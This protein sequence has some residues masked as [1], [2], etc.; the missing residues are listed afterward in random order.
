MFLELIFVFSLCLCITIVSCTCLS[1]CHEEA[2]FF[3]ALALYFFSGLRKPFEDYILPSYKKV[4]E[5]ARNYI[6]KK[7]NKK[8]FSELE[9]LC[10]HPLPR[11]TLLPF[12]G[13]TEPEGEFGHYHSLLKGCCLPLRQ[14]QER[15]LHDGTAATFVLWKETL[16]PL[17]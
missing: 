4:T 1:F 11:L 2:Q 8:A 15:A 6:R 3:S 13:L 14:C 16:P 12:P 7:T 9:L 5:P 17:N 10:F